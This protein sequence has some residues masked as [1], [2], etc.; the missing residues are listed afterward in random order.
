MHKVPTHFCRH[1][2]ARS[3]EEHSREH[4]MRA[5]LPRLHV[6]LY[7]TSLVCKVFQNA[8]A[9]LS[10]LETCL[11]PS[12]F[13]LISHC[14]LHEATELFCS[15]LPL[16][17]H[18]SDLHFIL[19]SYHYTPLHIDS[20]SHKQQRLLFCSYPGIRGQ[21]K[22]VHGALDLSTSCHTTTTKQI[23]EAEQFS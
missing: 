5:P 3:L 11:S 22:N 9:K 21:L 14:L 10:L 1:L 13:H 20:S 7:L 15:S 18:L 2:T 17:Y 4:L 6:E 12:L 16:L 8:W 23:Q 19:L